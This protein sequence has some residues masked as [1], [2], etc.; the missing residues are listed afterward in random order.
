MI[1]MCVCMCVC[2][3]VEMRKC[4]CVEW[5]CVCFS[6]FVIRYFVSF[7]E[8]LLFRFVILGVSGIKK[9]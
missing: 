7:F 6:R 9:L 1:G 2:V 3:C 5:K 4:V 8:F